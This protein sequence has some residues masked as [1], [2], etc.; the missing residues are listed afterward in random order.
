[1]WKVIVV[2]VVAWLAGGCGSDTLYRR[3]NGSCEFWI[4][5][6]FTAEEIEAFTRAVDRWDAT[7]AVGEPCSVT[8]DDKDPNVIRE[9]WGVYGPRWEARGAIR[10]HY[11][12]FDDVHIWS[13][14]PAEG[15]FSGIEFFEVTA[16]HEIG[17]RLGIE[18]H[19]WGAVSN[20]GQIHCIT[21]DDLL[22]VCEPGEC[23][24]ECGE[25]SDDD[26]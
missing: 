14:H 3:D 13:P 12:P 24:P 10:G 16:L 25:G 2:A 26:Y 17:H 19:S 21:K 18:H 20:E 15:S 9:A 11:S 5:P 7:G 23:T 22:Q 6:E 1:M 4:S 8:I